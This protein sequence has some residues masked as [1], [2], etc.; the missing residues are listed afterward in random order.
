M[1]TMRTMNV[2]MQCLL[3]LWLPAA[4]L[5]AAPA[6]AQNG[7]AAAVLGGLTEAMRAMG[8]YGVRFSVT[9]GEMRTEGRYVVAGDSYYMRLGDA[10]VYCD[11]SVRYEVDNARREVSVDGVEAASRNILDNPARA[12]EFLDDEYRPELLSESDGRAELRLIP[13]KAG[14]ATGAVTL[15]VDTATKRPVT[16]A[17]DFD[18]ERVTVAIVG[19]TSEPEP[20]P[21]FD[22]RR[23]EGYEVIDFR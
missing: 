10:E 5:L 11:G 18:G 17:Y 22:S 6:F 8:S 2:K 12:F 3:G 20:L 1:K 21:H 19:I 13:R 23:Y 16:L 14:A 4:L 9:A 7:R 15:T